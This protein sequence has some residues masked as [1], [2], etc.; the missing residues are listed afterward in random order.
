MPAITEDTGLIRQ[1]IAY[2]IELYRELTEENG[3][4]SL[5][6]QNQVVDFILA[7]P[8][9]RAAVAHWGV[10]SRATRRRPRRLGDCRMMP[11]T[12]GSGLCPR[13]W[14]IPVSSPSRGSAKRRSPR[15]LRADHTHM[16]SRSD[17]PRVRTVATKAAM[18]VQITTVCR[19]VPVWPK[20]GPGW[21][22]QDRA[23]SS[24]S[25]SDA[26]GAPP[27]G[28]AAA[29]RPTRQKRS[30][31]RGQRRE[32]RARCTK[33][34]SPPRAPRGARAERE[35]RSRPGPQHPHERGQRQDE[36]ER[37]G[38]CHHRVVEP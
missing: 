32:Q 17:G 13:L 6:T 2:A 9:L 12:G 21:R 34:R 4:P 20:P 15:W 28:P 7:D 29:G 5:G 16:V 31:W 36:A 27:Q 10:W 23:T 1:A 35:A 24:R 11:P 14:G 19:N 8:E 22:P 26:R 38:S 3:A 33:R 30:R 37:D 25:R 18:T